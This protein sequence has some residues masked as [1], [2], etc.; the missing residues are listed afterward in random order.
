MISL[1]VILCFESCFTILI[2][3]LCSTC[4]KLVIIINFA[5]TL[6]FLILL[7]QIILVYSVIIFYFI[8]CILSLICCLCLILI[9]DI[10]HITTDLVF[11][12]KIVVIFFP[13][14]FGICF[15]DSIII[16]LGFNSIV[17][18]SCINFL[19]VGIL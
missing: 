6:L 7:L 18:L 13:I 3:L 5:L 11:P 17:I 1:S 4:Y 10:I 9:I 19:G 8:F 15:L 2:I 16:I 12:F 14:F